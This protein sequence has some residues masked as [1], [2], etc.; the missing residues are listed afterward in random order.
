MSR[1]AG[2]S[3]VLS[4]L[5]VCFFAVALFQ[6]DLPRTR[7]ARRRISARE[8]IARTSSP[9]ASRTR[10]EPGTGP[11]GA[12]SA[13]FRGATASKP[14]SNSMYQ[15]TSRSPAAVP[16]SRLLDQQLGRG[17]DHASDRP[18]KRIHNASAR[19]SGRM[20]PAPSAGVQRTTD[21]TR[22]AQSAF[23]SALES[24]TLEDVS[25]RVYGTPEHGDLLWRANRDTLP[26][27]NTPLSTGML[28]RTPGIH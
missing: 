17:N 9:D 4:V 24:E 16:D 10:P 15:G 3:I 5:I 25:S 6:R 20:L 13:V 8:G 14:S 22:S 19:P 26:K 2:P 12:S 27:R 21:S 1:R 28:L 18:G 23:T 7:S 11:A